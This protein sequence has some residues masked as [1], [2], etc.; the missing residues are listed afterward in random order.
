MGLNSSKSKILNILI[1]ASYK[2]FRD[3]YKDATIIKC[4]KKT[5]S[6]GNNI[7][8]KTNKN[9]GFNENTTYII[10]S[11][12][13]VTLIDESISVLNTQE[14]NSITSITS[15]INNQI[16][17]QKAVG[18][19]RAIF[20]KGEK[21][22]TCFL[23]NSNIVA[24]VAS[25][26][27][28]EKYGKLVELYTSFYPKKVKASSVY[29]EENYEKD[30]NT[31]AVFDYKEDVLD[32]WLGVS[33]LELS[34][35]N[36][37]DLY[38]IA[39]NGF[40]NRPEASEKNEKDIKNYTKEIS[41]LYKLSDLH[42]VSVTMDSLM[43]SSNEMNKYKKCIGAPIVYKENNND[44]YIVGFLNSKNTISKISNN[45]MNTL[46]QGII[47]GKKGNNLKLDM[48]DKLNFSNNDFGPSDSKF[49]S[50]FN[51][52][53]LVDMDLSSNSIKPQGT[54]YLAQANFPNLKTLNLSFCDIGDNGLI[55]L[56]SAPFNNLEQLFLFH[57]DLSY[58]SI[59]YLCKADFAPNLI[60]LS[61]CE[62]PLIK[63]EGIKSFK[64]Q[65]N[66]RRLTVLNLNIT[67]ITDNAIKSLTESIMPS[68][69]IIRLQKNNLTSDIINDISGWEMNGIT[70]DID[71]SIRKEELMS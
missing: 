65:S 32:E 1:E 41:E 57:N 42:Q 31:L 56:S 52:V 8:E 34:D 59:D 16:F 27:Y 64:K 44:T 20:K 29:F 67:G 47:K 45:N 14:A 33:I 49:I 9:D 43:S 71:K 68:L 54:Y 23:I 69:R 4:S 50:E 30:E 70:V 36:C 17:P 11:T 3:S 6:I 55:H 7:L 24:T 10:N 40:E 37:K 39:S 63:D 48:I 12:N 51:L 26:L 66:W 19:I 62:N 60:V 38:L 21:E 25:N 35:L 18:T 28:N 15:K 2:N 53:N 58:I 46:I 22:G 5:I 13:S 61:L